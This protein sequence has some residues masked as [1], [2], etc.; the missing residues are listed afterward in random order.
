MKFDIR[1]ARGSYMID[2]L[3]HTLVALSSTAGTSAAQA[4]FVGFTVLSSFGAGVVPAVQS[5]ALCVIQADATEEEAFNQVSQSQDQVGADNGATSTESNTQ[6][7]AKPIG[8]GTGTLFGAFAV[9]QATGQMILGVRTQ[10]SQ[11]SRYAGVLI[12]RLLF[13]YYST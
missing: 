2:I 1:L 3:S 12:S 9:L 5:L 7:T 6:K 10:L 11:K 4:A 13:L 8:Q